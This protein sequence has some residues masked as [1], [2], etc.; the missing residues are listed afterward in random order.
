[1]VLRPGSEAGPALVQELQEFAKRE[2]AAY[3]YP[4]EIEFLSELPRDP[5]GK[6]QRRMLRQR[7]ADRRPSGA[8][9]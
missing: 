2:M 8:S 3:K 9:E 1:V 7:A 6:I 5:V 4:R